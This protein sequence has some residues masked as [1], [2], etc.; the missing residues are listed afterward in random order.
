MTQGGLIAMIAFTRVGMI[1]WTVL[2]IVEPAS[3]ETE[4]RI[5][6]IEI[7]EFT[8]RL[9]DVGADRGRQ[10]YQP[11]SVVEPPG[12]VLTIRTNDGLEGHYRG[13]M[14]VKPML[15]QIEMAAAE[16]LL[17][18]DPLER[19]A[20]WQDLWRAFRSTDHLGVGPIDIALWDL[21]GKHYG[22]SV[23]GL[24]GGYRDR[25]PAYASTF[26]SDENGGLDSPAAYA[27]FA[28]EC[29]D[30]GYPAFKAHPFGYAHRDVNVARAVGEAVGDEMDLMF[31]PANEYRTYA[32]ALQVGRTLDEYDYFFYE[33]P[34]S[35]AGESLHM[36][37]RLARRL[38]TPLLGLEHSRTGPYGIANYVSEDVFEFVRGDAHLN[39]GIT[40]AMKVAN[41]TE[42]FGIDIE[43]HV[44]GPA[45]LHCMSA[46]RNTNYFEH[47]LLHPE[48]EWMASQGFTEDVEDIDDAGHIPVP[49]GDGLGVDIDWEFVEHRQTDHTVISD[50][51][52]SGLA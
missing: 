10:V 35:D 8:Y 41:L 24:L 42:A 31:D 38:K 14:F 43:F 32:E 33:D 52:A 36:G 19:E 12:F 21:A 7:H 20:I 49:D 28:E 46:V 3:V 11:G 51:G 9:E 6:E 34:M 47:G 22:D 39:G 48:V 4:M 29:R 16:F 2:S 18:R 25:V 15:A 5:E 44:G 37:R 45:H 13:F 23:S 17:G 26:M 50:Q 40:G 27:A 1:V 30:R